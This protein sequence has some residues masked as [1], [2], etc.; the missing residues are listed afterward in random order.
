[1]SS[2]INK[3][4]QQ[5]QIATVYWVDDDNV[6]SADLDL[7]KLFSEAVGVV[8]KL[9]SAPIGKVIGSAP[10]NLRQELR[11]LMKTLDGDENAELNDSVPRPDRTEEIEG[12]L[13]KLVEAAD[14]PKG[15]LQLLL[16]SVDGRLSAPQKAALASL[17][18]PQPGT[19]SHTWRKLSFSDW[20]KQQAAIL[21]AH[22]ADRPAL[23]LLDQQNTQDQSLL[24][25]IAI[26][27]NV[28]SDRANHQAFKFLVVTNTVTPEGEF[29]HAI[30]LARE[31]DMAQVG[32]TSPLFTVAKSRISRSLTSKPEE[33]GPTLESHFVSLLRR[34]RLSLLNQELTE[35]AKGVIAE[36]TERAFSRL[37]EITLHEF[38]YAVT[39]S[40]QIEGVSELDTLLRLLAIEQR[41]AMLNQVVSSSTLRS[42]I[43][44][45][46][47]VPVDI[48]KKEISESKDLMKLRGREIYWP[49]QAVNKLHQ[50][51]AAGD[52]FE[53][54]A[55]EAKDYYVVLGNDCDLMLRS[56][57]IRNSV[58]VLLAKLE[59]GNGDKDLDA[60]LEC[61][62]PQN[63]DL[64]RVPMNKV[65]SA[66]MDILDLCW[67]NA[68]GDCAWK[69][70]EN[71][72]TLH[73]LKSQ[74]ERAT[75]LR[76]LL[77]NQSSLGRIAAAAPFPLARKPTLKTKR[78]DFKLRRVGR[79]NAPYAQGLL[80]KFASVFARPSYEHNYSNLRDV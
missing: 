5:L 45:I 4:L 67:L 44:K 2:E 78:V 35:L 65:I 38:M 14:D 20:G 8:S 36:A 7:D 16:D 62:L 70:A 55:G 43:E 69:K 42:A 60:M 59:T 75:I 31:I 13:T 39:Q 71:H 11:Q 22:S 29:E 50:P 40:S 28:C 51:V 58:L 76:G 41:D 15:Q 66:P 24:D 26:L 10:Q 3:V 80:A 52:I 68:D 27:R 56:T 54:G 12:K 63:R 9:G 74:K 79:M 19:S 47:D 17:F 33:V 72:Q 21:K 77:T 73:L 34:L 30:N 46:R 64:V 57:G 6:K 48:R 61:P 49:E 32:I 37:R 1:M 23:V 53:V 25:G 18:K